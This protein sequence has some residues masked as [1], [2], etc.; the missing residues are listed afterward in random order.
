MEGSKRVVVQFHSNASC[1]AREI[2]RPAGE[3]AGLRDDG[4]GV[5]ECSQTKSAPTSQPDAQLCGFGGGCGEVGTL[6]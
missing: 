1:D 3:N 2:P 4:V 5:S 6:M